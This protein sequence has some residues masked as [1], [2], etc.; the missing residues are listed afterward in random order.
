MLLTSQPFRSGQLCPGKHAHLP[1]THTHTTHNTPM[2]AQ[3]FRPQIMASAPTRYQ[4]VSSRQQAQY[5]VDTAVVNGTLFEAE[6][7]G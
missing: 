5:A 1:H 4:P 7:S 2:H 6:I 3:W